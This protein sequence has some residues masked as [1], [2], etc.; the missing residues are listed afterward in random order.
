MGRQQ[1]RTALDFLTWLDQH[2][3][4]LAHAGQPDIDTWL[5][6]GSTQRY[7]IRYFLDWACRHHLAGPVQ[8]PLRMRKNPDQILPEDQRW[9]QLQRCLHDPA[10]R[11]RS[12]SRAPCSSSTATPSAAP[13]S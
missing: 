1:I 8:V 11:T 6:S 2:G 4:D 9:Q 13:S 3:L 10:C 5:T 7:S 12:A